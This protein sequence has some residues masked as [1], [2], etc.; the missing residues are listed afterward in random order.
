MTEQLKR[1]VQIIQMRNY[2]DPKKYVSLLCSFLFFNILNMLLIFRF[3]KNPDKPRAIV[4]IG[5]VIEGPTEFKSSRL[6]KRER[7]Q[8]VLEEVMGDDSIR[9]YS[10]RVFNDIQAQKSAKVKT[11]KVAKKGKKSS[12]KVSSL[13]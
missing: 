2:M 10:K 4:H 7:K 5:T 8:T 9:R 13:Y 12:K 11:Y 1:D 3:Y 6:T